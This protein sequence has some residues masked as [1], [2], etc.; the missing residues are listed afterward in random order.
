MVGALFNQIG[1]VQ[2]P[3]LAIASEA[4]QSPPGEAWR[5]LR[6]ARNDG[7]GQW[8][9]LI[10][11]RSNGTASEIKFES[12]FFSGDRIVEILGSSLVSVRYRQPCI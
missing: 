7:D 8:G 6:F 1:P 2:N 3:P 9:N 12:G 4:K 10:G 5:L 11:N